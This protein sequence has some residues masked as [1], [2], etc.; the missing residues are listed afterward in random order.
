MRRNGCGEWQQHGRDSTKYKRDRMPLLWQL[1][2]NL[3]LSCRLRGY[4]GAKDTSWCVRHQGHTKLQAVSISGTPVRSTL[5]RCNPGRQ[6]RSADR[7]RGSEVAARFPRGK[8]AFDK[9]KNRGLAKPTVVGDDWQPGTTVPVA[10]SSGRALRGV[11]AASVHQST[12]PRWSAVRLDRTDCIPCNPVVEHRAFRRTDAGRNRH[13]AVDDGERKNHEYRQKL[14]HPV[15]LH[16]R[17]A[18]AKTNRIRFP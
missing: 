4:C 13:H 11:P 6:S 15:R 7:Y 17:G 16:H 5:P 10:P 9:G 8:T 18:S 2:E 1:M 3:H 14:P 12:V